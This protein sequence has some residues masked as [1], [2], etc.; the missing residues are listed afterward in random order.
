MK[1]SA[2]L[3]TGSIGTRAA[4]L[5]FTPSLVTIDQKI[6]GAG[7]ER[8]ISFDPSS[9]E[10]RK[11]VS[12]ASGWAPPVDNSSIVDQSGAGIGT[13]GGQGVTDAVRG[14]ESGDDTSE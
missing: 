7:R 9:R 14:T 5:Q 10:Y 13:G 4:S 1:W 2:V 6:P 8:V 11:Y 12:E 3:V